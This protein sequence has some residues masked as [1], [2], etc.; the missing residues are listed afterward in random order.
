MANAV[1]RWEQRL[2]PAHA[3]EAPGIAGG[4]HAAFRKKPRRRRTE[5]F[6]QHRGPQEKSERYAI[7]PSLRGSHGQWRACGA[8]RRE[9]A[10][11]NLGHYRIVTHFDKAAIA[12][13]Q[14]TNKCLNRFV[15]AMSEFAHRCC[16]TAYGKDETMRSTIGLVS[17][18]FSTRTSTQFSMSAPAELGISVP[19]SSKNVNSSS[20]A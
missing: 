10:G 12:R 8:R 18:I 6:P 14:G 20:L 19:K 7:A 9:V 15:I 13:L 4:K 17:P 1:G 16:R 11:G 5:Q 2:G 3:G